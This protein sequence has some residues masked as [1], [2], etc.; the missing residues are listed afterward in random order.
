[1]VYFYLRVVR[2]FLS[3][4]F[5]ITKHKNYKLLEDHDKKNLFDVEEYLTNRDKVKLK[6]I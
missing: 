2:H 1:M 5:D 6:S 3:D 4:K